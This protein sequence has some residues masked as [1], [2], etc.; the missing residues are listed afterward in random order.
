[1][2]SFVFKTK[3]GETACPYEGATKTKYFLPGTLIDQPTV[4]AEAPDIIVEKPVVTD[5]PSTRNA[6]FNIQLQNACETNSGVSFYLQVMEDSNP[7]GAKIS[8]DGASLATGRALWLNAGQVLS[9]TITLERG[10]DAMDYENIQLRLISECD[11]TAFDLVNISAHFI[12]SCSDV[13]ITAPADQWLLNTQ[14]AANE[15]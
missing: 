14:S 11:T 4:R 8:M 15:D 7:D 2:S 13:N 5:I 6:T 3:G 9:K 1:D 12:P 10:P